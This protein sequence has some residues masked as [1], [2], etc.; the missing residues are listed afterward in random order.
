MAE[1]RDGQESAFL[2]GGL[3]DYICPPSGVAILWNNIPG[4]KKITW[5]QGST[6]GFVAPV[7]YPGRDI[8]RE[9]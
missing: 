6:H 9:E 1:G 7:D 4:N 2:R 5:V 3:G 8:V